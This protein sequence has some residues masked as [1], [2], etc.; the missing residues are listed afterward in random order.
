LGR[1]RTYQI[2]GTLSPDEPKPKIT[3][4]GRSMND[5]K[6]N[7]YVGAVDTTLKKGGLR[8]SVMQ[9]NAFFQLENISLSFFPVPL[10]LSDYRPH[11]KEGFY[12]EE[13]GGT[14]HTW[15]WSNGNAQVEIVNSRTKPGDVQLEFGLGT[16]EPRRVE[17]FFKGV[18]KTSCDLKSSEDRPV[19]LAIEV[20]PGPNILEFRTNRPAVR[21]RQGTDRRSLAFKVIDF[22][23][24][25]VPA[26][27]QKPVQTSR[28]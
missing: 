20:Q 8:Q 4:D 22:H 23:I 16:L 10:R 12:S 3:I 2:I 28:D 6:A 19:R 27:K 24:A 11:F 17:I 26:G 1:Q 15:Y 9:S 14:G 25:E 21:P 7:V 13:G 5:L 18:F